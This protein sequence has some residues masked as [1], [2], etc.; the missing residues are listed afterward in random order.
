ML[1]D[2][3]CSMHRYLIRIILYDSS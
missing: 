2:C 3:I 1:E